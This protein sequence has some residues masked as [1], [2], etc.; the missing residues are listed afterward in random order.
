MSLFVR[1]ARRL[2]FSL[3]MTLLALG[4][5][6]HEADAQ[7][8]TVVSQ[9]RDG[10][11]GLEV[12]YGQAP[13]LFAF[14]FS[15][16][17]TSWLLGVDRVTTETK[18]GTRVDRHN[19]FKFR[20]GLRKWTSE[21]EGPFKLFAGA[22][23]SFADDIPDQT[24]S[25]GDGYG[26]GEL[27]TAFFVWPHLSLGAAGELSFAYGKHSSGSSVDTGVDRGRLYVRALRVRGGAAIYLF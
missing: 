23:I 14:L 2:L 21:M 5:L 19:S 4:C 7:A 6:G 24:S 13:G 25:L 15:S 3:C 9:L 27:G 26:Y 1:R 12:S 8:D 10:M 22:G 20:I 11:V 18:V 16:P 17:S